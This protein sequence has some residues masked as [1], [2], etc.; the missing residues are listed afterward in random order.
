MFCLYIS[1]FSK[2]PGFLPQCKHAVQVLPRSANNSGINCIS[3]ALASSFCMAL[4]KGLSVTQLD[5]RVCIMLIVALQC[6][7][8]LAVV[9]LW[10]IN[11]FVSQW[12]V[13]LCSS[14]SVS[15]KNQSYFP[16]SG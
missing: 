1:S 3:T 2:Y 6:Y 15:Q 16:N 10:E 8:I 5:Y 12:F 13:L 14:E 7:Q 11:M 9:H 4:N